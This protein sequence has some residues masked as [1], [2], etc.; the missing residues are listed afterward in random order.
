MGHTHGKDP[1]QKF[2][3]L[4]NCLYK[5]AHSEKNLAEF[6]V[7]SPVVAWCDA[8]ID[9]DANQLDNLNTL[10]KLGLIANRQRKLIH[11]FSHI[12]AC[13]KFIKNVNNVF[14]I[15]SGSMGK[16]LVPLIHD[17]EQ[18]HSIYIFCMCK[19]NYETWAKQY[20]KIHGVFTRVEDLCQSLHLYFMGPRF[21]E[22]D[23]IQYEILNKNFRPKHPEEEEL[24]FIYAILS[25]LMLVHMG[26]IKQGDM[27]D[28]CRTECCNTFQK[29]LIGQYETNYRQHNSVW[30]FTRDD[31]FQEIVNRAL[32]LNDLRTLCMMSPFVNDLIDTL[33]EL[34]TQ[35]KPSLP[36]N[37]HIYCSQLIS[38]D[39]FHRLVDNQ[40]GLMCINEFIFANADHTIPLMHLQHESSQKPNN[41]TVNVIF[42][43]LIQKSGYPSACYANIGSISPFVHE[44]EYI[45]SMSSVYRIGRMERLPEVS[46]V[47]VVNLTLIN[48]DDEQLNLIRQSICADE[49]YLHD[50]LSAGALIVKSK[51]NQYKSTRKLFELI[52]QPGT[53]HIRPILL[54]YNMG[55]IYDALNEF[56]RALDQYKHAMILVR[57][58]EYDGTHRDSLCLVP[59]FANM[60]WTYQQMNITNSAYDH[61]FRALNIVLNDIDNTI[62]HNE[63]LAQAYC[64]LGTILQLQ[65]QVSQAKCSYENALRCLYK[66][67]PHHHPDIKTVQ[68]MISLLTSEPSDDLN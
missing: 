16:T 44:K 10:L 64:S 45:I 25:K 33:E 46:S 41:S 56:D 48:E 68:N 11:T 67:L 8:N 13:Q 28:F 1:N 51:I 7:D 63:L 54:H 42:K 60:G 65:G 58:H 6:Y 39:E 35:Q 2:Q 53:K 17:L 40:D 4:Y 50:A 59:L 24:S 36:N 29:K 15:V 32:Q 49:N 20:K 62:F 52:L 30:W 23:K 66:Y 47:R 38:N 19:A 37:F 57:S 43:I 55:I 27:I 14:L 9:K 12:E 61:A 5:T 26:S 21:S 31:F 34:Y 3:H 22:L 18:I